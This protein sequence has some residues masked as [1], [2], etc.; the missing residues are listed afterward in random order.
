MFARMLA[1]YMNKG[2]VTSFKDVFAILLDGITRVTWVKDVTNNCTLCN[3]WTQFS[4]KTMFSHIHTHTGY[5]WMA[6]AALK[7]ILIYII[8]GGIRKQ[9]RK[10]LDRMK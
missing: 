8:I 10:M 6:R 4:N 9:N 2:S 3:I 7:Y 1:L 5:Q